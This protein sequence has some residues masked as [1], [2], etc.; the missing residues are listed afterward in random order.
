MKSEN[1]LLFQLVHGVSFLLR[2]LFF[3]ELFDLFLVP[4]FFDLLCNFANLLHLL[5][6]E[7]ITQFTPRC[8]QRLRIRS[9]LLHYK[10]I[11]FFELSSIAVLLKDLVFRFGSRGTLTAVTLASQLLGRFF[12][13]VFFF[14]FEALLKL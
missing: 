7:L 5:F 3:G 2:I 10:T 13:F 12:L 9:R 1:R 4:F 6:M 8:Y 11:L 14:L